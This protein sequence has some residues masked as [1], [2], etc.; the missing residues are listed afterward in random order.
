MEIKSFSLVRSRDKIVAD[1]FVPEA[2]VDVQLED[3]VS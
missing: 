3:H 1:C 2:T